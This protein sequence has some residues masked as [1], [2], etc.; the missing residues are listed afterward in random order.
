MIWNYRNLII[1]ATCI[2]WSILWEFI[3]LVQQVEKWDV[4]PQNMSILSLMPDH[5]SG[6]FREVCCFPSQ[7]TTNGKAKANIL[8]SKMGWAL[9]ISIKLILHDTMWLIE[10][11]LKLE[12]CVQNLA[13]F[14]TWKILLNLQCF[15]FIIWIV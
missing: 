6:D 8:Q 3:E 14:F 2:H 13:L 7:K 1:K 9:N 5:L 10:R 11:I 15:S 12:F 4:W